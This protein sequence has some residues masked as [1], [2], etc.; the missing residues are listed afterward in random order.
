MNERVDQM[1]KFQCREVGKFAYDTWITINALDEEF[2]ATQFAEHCDDD[3][4]RF[5]DPLRD[6][7]TVEVKD[8]TGKLCRFQVSFEYSKDFIAHEVETE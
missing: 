8:A 1:A 7:M 3:G 2:A 4:Q 5:A 6:E